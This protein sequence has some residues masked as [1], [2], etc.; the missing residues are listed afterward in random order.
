MVKKSEEMAV[1]F[2]DITDST[3]LYQKLGD[4]AARELIGACLAGLQEVLPRHDGRLVKTVGDAIM[5]VFPA[6][7]GAVRAA[8]EMQTAFSNRPSAGEAIRVHIG[9][10]FGPVLLEEADVYGDT[11]NAAAY[12]AAAA[13]SEQI[14]TTEEV[15]ARLSPGL[16]SSVRPIF[17]AVLKGSS[18]ESTVYQVLWRG[19]EHDI[20]TVNLHSN[21]VIPGDTGSL[22]IT[23]EGRQLSVDR[24]QPSI[25]IGRSADCDLVV[26][27][28]YAS[29]RHMTIKMRR[30]RFYLVDHSTNGT[31]V[32]NGSEELHVLRSELLLDDNGEISLGRRRSEGEGERI[33]YARNRR[34]MYR[35]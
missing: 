23:Y 28:P 1:L 12:L 15:W 20:T 6:A 13:M 26:D 5:C 17:H 35:V 7:E 4:A 14:I 29:R 18:S 10:H 3:S 31:F 19:A 9:L 2:A 11:V 32:W 22:L 25:T 30:T 8:R 21:R 27:D 33:K 16:R 34:S 24:S